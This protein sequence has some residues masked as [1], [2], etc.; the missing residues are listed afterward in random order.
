MIRG[1]SVCDAHDRRAAL[2]IEEH[3]DEPLKRRGDQPTITREATDAT[4]GA[5]TPGTSAL[6]VTLF[7]VV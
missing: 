4:S 3:P 1:R 6:L 7:A 5:M 2:A